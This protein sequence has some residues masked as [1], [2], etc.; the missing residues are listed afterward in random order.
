MALRNVVLLARFDLQQTGAGAQLGF[1]IGSVVIGADAGVRYIFG[2]ADKMCPF[3]IRTGAFDI[4]PSDCLDQGD[5]AVDALSRI[6][7]YPITL[8][9]RIG[10]G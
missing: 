1:P 10:H 5:G 4:Q 6:I 7:T 9:I 8:F 2:D 3:T